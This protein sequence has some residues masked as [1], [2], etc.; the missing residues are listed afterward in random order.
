MRDATRTDL[1]SLQQAW[2]S[3]YSYGEAAPVTPNVIHKTCGGKIEFEVAPAYGMGGKDRYVCKGEHPS[4]GKCGWAYKVDAVHAW[5][6]DMIAKA[7]AVVPAPDHTIYKLELH[8]AHAGEDNSTH[9]R[10]R[11]AS[12]EEIGHYV[13][14]DADTWKVK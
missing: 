12:P 2:Y 11:P 7:L 14:G 9:Y 1:Y 6:D 3:L 4:F 10:L 8:V 5:T 13:S